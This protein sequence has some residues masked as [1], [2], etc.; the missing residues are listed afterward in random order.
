MLKVISFRPAFARPAGSALG[1][2]A[3]TSP[4]SI[5]DA[6]RGEPITLG[7]GDERVELVTQKE[8]LSTAENYRAQAAEF[9]GLSYQI[10]Q[11]LIRNTPGIAGATGQ[12]T[13]VTRCGALMGRD[14]NQIV[15][16]HQHCPARFPNHGG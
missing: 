6:P 11:P 13:A 14:Q 2:L 4:V 3:R 10:A 7:A 8:A 12:T 5:S 15:G 16:S 9:G 1:G